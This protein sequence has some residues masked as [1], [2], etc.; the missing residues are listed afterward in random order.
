MEPRKEELCPFS[1]TQVGK[2]NN[3]SRNTTGVTVVPARGSSNVPHISPQSPLPWHTLSLLGHRTS[4]LARESQH[5]ATGT[6]GT[7]EGDSECLENVCQ[8]SLPQDLQPEERD[9]EVLGVGTTAG[10]NKSVGFRGNSFLEAQPQISYKEVRE[11]GH[12]S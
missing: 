1:Q 12:I 6:L 11:W 2:R 10:G 9:P 3:W 4:T 8:T 5:G 7:F